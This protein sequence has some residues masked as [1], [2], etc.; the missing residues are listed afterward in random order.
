[1]RDTERRP[2]DFVITVSLSG[3]AVSGACTS[4]HRLQ[5]KLKTAF[6][7]AQR[8]WPNIFSVQLQQV[9]GDETLLVSPGSV[10]IIG[11]EG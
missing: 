8:R 7:L 5:Q 4:T 9:E 3:T 6:A 2:I 11:H 10:A 1:M